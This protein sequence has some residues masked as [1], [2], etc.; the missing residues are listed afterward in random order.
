FPLLL[1]ANGS[2]TLRSL[3]NGL[4]ER[5][6][7]RAKTGSLNNTTTL[8]GYLGRPEGMLIVAAMYNGSRTT[9]ARQAQW[10]LFRNLG[11]E[12]VVIPPAGDVGE[13]LILGGEEVE[14]R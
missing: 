1:P 12:G 13:E 10:E 11:V 8:V 9:N 14:A 6:V 7:V 5:G 3:A 2:G 4:P